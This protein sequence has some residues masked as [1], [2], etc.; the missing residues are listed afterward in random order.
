MSTATNPD[1]AKPDP[2][3]EATLDAALRFFKVA[4]QS[5]PMPTKRL[6]EGKVHYASFGDELQVTKDEAKAEIQKVETTRPLDY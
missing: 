6:V 3:D 4:E 5:S 1:P 2:T